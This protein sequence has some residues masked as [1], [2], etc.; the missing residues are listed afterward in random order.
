MC[1]KAGL[2]KTAKAWGEPCREV[3]GLFYPELRNIG[4][5]SVRCQRVKP[6]ILRQPSLGA[7]LVGSGLRRSGSLWLTIMPFQPTADSN[8]LRPKTGSDGGLF[9]SPVVQHAWSI[10][11]SLFLP[12]DLWC[13][14]RPRLALPR[15]NTLIIQRNCQNRPLHLKRPPFTLS[16]SFSR[17]LP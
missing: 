3:V 5:S 12:S 10:P 16:D 6:G 17:I 13:L 15:W 14:E 7:F 8:Q 9:R 2:Q 4:K 11:G 1:S